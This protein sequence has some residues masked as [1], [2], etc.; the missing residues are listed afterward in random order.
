MFKSLLAYEKRFVANLESFLCLLTNLCFKVENDGGKRKIEIQFS[1]IIFLTFL[2]P[3]Q[4]I[5]NI[6]ILPF[7]K[8]S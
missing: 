5:S 2:L 3:C 6:I 4:S 8:L 7:L 1:A